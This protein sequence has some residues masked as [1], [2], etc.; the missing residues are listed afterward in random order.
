MKPKVTKNILIVRLSAIGDVVMASPLPAAI[1]RVNSD[2]KITWLCQAECKDLLKDQPN[3]DQVIVWPRREW[4]KLW[5]GRKYLQLG[6]QIRQFRNLL[7]NE[8]FDL[9]LDL[10]GLLKSGYLTWLSGATK[11]IGLGSSEGSQLFMHQVITREG[12]NQD[13]IGSEYRYLAAEMEF[14]THSFDLQLGISKQSKESSMALLGEISDGPYLVVC[15]FTTRAQKHWFDDYWRST[16]VQLQARFELPVVLLGGPGDVDSAQR[17]CQDTNIIN[18]AGK[19]NLQE[20]AVIIGHSTGLIGVDTGLTHMGH[21]MKVPTL[22]L[23]GSTRPYLETGLS[24]SKVIY[25]DLHC[26]PCRR[27]PTCDGRFDCLREITPDMVLQEFSQL[28]AKP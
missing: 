27:N 17:L 3:V 11:R 21:A 26:A 2:T 13:L 25:L 10:Q 1:K 28:R 14:D 24:T 16:A 7:R 23:F 20:A 4:Q 6:K 15:P 22:G 18:L 8:K 12:G 9:A 5:D 19:T